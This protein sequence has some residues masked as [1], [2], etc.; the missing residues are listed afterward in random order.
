MRVLTINPE[1]DCLTRYL[2]VWTE[3]VIKTFE[4]R[5]EFISLKRQNATRERMI[6]TLIKKNIDVVLFNGHGSN[7]QIQGQNEIIF[8]TDDVSIL[9]GKIVHAL[10]CNTAKTLGPIAKDSGAKEYVGYDEQFVLFYQNSK[11]GHPDSDNTAKLFLDPAFIAPRALLEGK[12][13]NEAVELAR[14]AY[15]RSIKEALN[16]DIQSDNDQFIGWL[17]WDRD[18][19]TSC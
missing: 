6:G 11:V 17:F 12:T 4:N 5:C 7:T 10:S 15:N 2:L 3:K 16:S 14:K 1:I 18:H 8:S 19:L 13:G 9:N